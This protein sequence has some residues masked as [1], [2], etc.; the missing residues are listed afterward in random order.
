MRDKIELLVHIDAPTRKEVLSWC[1]AYEAEIRELKRKL[2][3][4]DKMINTVLSNVY[5]TLRRSRQCKVYYDGKF[6]VITNPTRLENQTGY[7]V[8]TYD[9]N[10]SVD[11]LRDDIISALEKVH[12]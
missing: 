5:N 6:H 2:S 7:H 3:L 11:T 4:N 12:D 8:G 1:R 10:Y 9:E